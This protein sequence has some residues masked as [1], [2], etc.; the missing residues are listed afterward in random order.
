MVAKLLLCII[1]QETSH[2]S[3]CSNGGHKSLHTPRVFVTR[4]VRSTSCSGRPLDQSNNLR[5]GSRR[6]D[7]QTPLPAAHRKRTCCSLRSETEKF[8]WGRQDKSTTMFKTTIKMYCG[9]T[10]KT[11]VQQCLTHRLRQLVLLL[12]Q[13]YNNA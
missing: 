5:R 2:N 1:T 4:G 13:E 8:C 12:R 3:N 7:V 6:Q 9:L 11:R 10:I